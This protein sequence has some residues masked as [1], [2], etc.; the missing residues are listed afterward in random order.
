MTSTRRGSPA[1]STLPVASWRSVAL[2]T[3]HGGWSLAAEPAILGLAVAWSWSGLAI[4]LATMLAFV[5][6][7][8]VK[9][10]LVDRHRK[11]WLPRTS[12]AARIASVELVTLCGLAVV[13]W[14]GAPANF[15]LPLAL[16][17][18]LVGLEL[19]YDMRSRSR[20]LLPELA[21][22]IGIGSVAAAIG[23]AGGLRTTLAFGLWC[24]IGARATAA[25]AYVRVQILRT[26]ANPS[27]FWI[28][29]LAQV[30]AAVAVLVGWVLD[31]VPLAGVIVIAILGVLN[32]VAL[33]R[34]PQRAVAVGVQQTLVGL[35]VIGVT[36][37]AV[38]SLM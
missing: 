36:A 8:A 2:P 3:E 17:A 10:V 26:K 16:A 34:P 21:G 6:R 9:V 32:I 37:V 12:L 11:R 33:R 38:R 35:V 14:I 30:A 27:P 5:T 22:A 25:I 29:D 18:P 1:T 24:V 20:R 15:W 19:W 13:A 31:A 23:L 7:T 28:S 4:G